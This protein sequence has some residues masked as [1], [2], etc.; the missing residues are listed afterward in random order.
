[1]CEYRISSLLENKTV[2]KF[3]SN[4]LISNREISYYKTQGKR[5]FVVK[6]FNIS[7]GFAILNT[8]KVSSILNWVKAFVF[9]SSP[10]L[11]ARS[12]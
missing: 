8:N 12:Q 4:T 2:I 9:S 6:L 3:Q 10:L 1:M 5:A 7:R 11:L